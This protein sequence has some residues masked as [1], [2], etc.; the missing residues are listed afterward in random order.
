MSNFDGTLLFGT[1]VD[2]TGFNAGVNGMEGAGAK[3]GS[4]MKRIGKATAVAFT[5]SAAA[6]GALTKK[7]LDL[8]ANY[9]QLVGGVETLFKDSAGLV[10]QYAAEAY[11]T[12]GMSANEYM[13]TITGFSASLLQSLGGDTK[14]AAEIGDMAVK[15]MSD[16]ANKMGTDIGR[17]QDA[18]QG[19]AKQNYTMLDNL[20]LGYG[21]TKTEME[22][23]LKDAE[24]LTGKKYDISNLADVYNAI[25]AIQEEMGI[26]GTTAKEAMQTIEGSV[27]MTQA[28]WTNLLTGVA[29]DKADMGKL[30][31]NFVES[32]T[33]AA[34]NIM[35]RV[36]KILR[37][38]A[39]LVKELVPIITKALPKLVDEVL[40]ALLK[41]ASALIIGLVKALPPILKTIAKVLPKI[42]E[43]LIPEIMKVLPML[44]TVGVQAVVEIM[45]GFAKATP[46]VIKAITDSLPDIIK[47]IVDAIPIIVEAILDNLPLLIQCQI[48]IIIQ[49]A[50]AIVKSMPHILLAVAKVLKAMLSAFGKAIVSFVKV[51]V[52]IVK[53]LWKGISS[54]VKWIGKH[55]LDFAKKIP[56][57]IWKGLKAMNP[58]GAKAIKSLWNGM[59][60]S[61]NWLLRK[62]RGVGKSILKAFKKV[63]SGIRDIGANIIRGLWG[64]IADKV[65]WI[66]DKILG[67]VDN[68]KEWF[69]DF[70]GIHS[71]SK[72][73]REAVGAMVGAGI[74]H[75]I[76]DSTQFVV[77]KAD[78]FGK[79]VKAKLMT[80]VDTSGLSIGASKM[81]AE[82]FAGNQVIHNDNRVT[83]TQPVKTPAETARAI[84]LQ[85]TYGLAGAKV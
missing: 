82:S 50:A 1:K 36:V 35:P 22:R 27:K 65:E 5:A 11:K 37:G 24:K 15:D 69:K 53:A 57:W 80:T 38:F 18:Y 67:F 73:A 32:F 14:K 10:Q 79:T 29:D 76:E 7:S 51:G 75:G 19:F 39:D 34:K 52:K 3:F 66:R 31:D 81:Q 55:V 63:V 25:H 43:E 71:P 59:K 13:E 9:E 2:A 20:K 74:G 44:I 54:V 72:W 12:A 78:A 16:N 33:A 70:F 68:V 84:R 83:I 45:K 26:T 41:A 6:V 48:Q 58:T 49:L 60:S 47:A 17:I 8:Y 28:A 23:L 85:Q 21:G 42:L 64:G 40:P 4:A 61:V 30:I 77:E 62:V 46:V 56:K